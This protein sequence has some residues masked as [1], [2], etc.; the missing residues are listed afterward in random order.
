M[1]PS[2]H[3]CGHAFA[4]KAHWKRHV[5]TLHNPQPTMHSCPLL[6]CNYQ[7]SQKGNL[8]NHL[9]TVHSHI[10]PY[11]CGCSAAFKLKHQLTKHQNDLG[12][13]TLQEDRVAISL[14]SDF[15]D[16]IY[17]I[18]DNSSLFDISYYGAC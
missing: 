15:D 6:W 2:Q 10:R 3:C 5:D 4:K 16:A 13:K 11:V 9:R 12:H 18:L 7:T 1:C 8:V 17:W 14:A